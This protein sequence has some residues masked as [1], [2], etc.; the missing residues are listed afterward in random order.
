MIYEKE[1]YSGWSTINRY[2][3]EIE[4]VED[5]VKFNP[6]GKGYIVRIV[7]SE[8]E[9]ISDGVAQTLENAFT[10]CMKGIV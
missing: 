3:L 2:N 8:Q 10:E 1:K 6:T 5:D 9:I 4:E 7:D